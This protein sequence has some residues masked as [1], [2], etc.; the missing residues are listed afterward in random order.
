MAK[1]SKKRAIK[2]ARDK[3][4]SGS[5]SQVAPSSSESPTNEALV[6]S[7]SVINGGSKGSTVQKKRG[8]GKAKGVFPCHN[9]KCE[10]HDRRFIEKKI[11]Q[12]ITIKFHQN[13]TWHWITFSEYPKEQLNMLYELYKEAQFETD[14]LVLEREV[15]DEHVKRR[16]PDWMWRLREQCVTN[17]IPQDEWYKHPPD[18]VTPTIWKEM[19]NKWNN[20]KWKEKSD[21]NK[22]NCK[23]NQAIIATTGSVPMA[24]CRKELEKMD[25]RKSEV[26]S[27]GEIV[28]DSQ[29]FFE[30]TGPPTCGRVLGMGA[31]VKPKDVYGPSSSS[32]CSKRCQ[33]D[34]LKE[35]EDFE[36]RFKET[37]DKSSVE[38][39]EL[40][41]EINQLKEKMPR[42]I[43]NAL[44]KMG[45]NSMQE[46]TTQTDAG[47]GNQSVD[48]NT[49]DDS[50]EED[51]SDGSQKE[52]TDSNDG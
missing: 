39:M 20:R 25:A 40:Q 37:E 8:R 50:E 33:A 28:N 34:R 42:M 2:Q 7:N 22:T 30:V 13:I 26:A 6:S 31:G 51:D 44:K 29:I 48:E 36:L 17:K 47:E 21:R 52:N 16:Y 35:K 27:Q 41:G 38:K 10:I 1:K 19:C 4:D 49:E 46:P 5:Q 32:Q 45:F 12:E 3:G 43:V 15:F 11:P 14:D 24:K 9:R 18:D 23:E